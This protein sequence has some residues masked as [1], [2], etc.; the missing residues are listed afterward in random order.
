MRYLN[1][2]TDRFLVSYEI[3]LLKLTWP[4]S[5]TGI[6]TLLNSQLIASCWSH[7]HVNKRKPA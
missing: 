7:I 3:E 4:I 5:T 2:S 6:L 1:Y